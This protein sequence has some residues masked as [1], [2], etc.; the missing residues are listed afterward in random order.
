MRRLGILLLFMTG[1][2]R[3]W[4]DGS[5]VQSG[6]SSAAHPR[7]E[8]GPSS[9]VFPEVQP[10]S[11]RAT[12]A[13]GSPT[14]DRSIGWLY[15]PVFSTD[16]PVQGPARP[17]VPQPGDIFLC[18]DQ[19]ILARWG[20]QLAGARSPHHSG[21]IIGRPD[22]GVAM[23]E[24]GPHDTLWVRVLDLSENLNKYEDEG[25]TIWIRRRKT[26]LTPEQSERLTEFAMKQNGK[27][28][29]WGRVLGQLTPFRSRG[30]WT[31]WVGGPHGGNRVSYF[32][33]ELVLETLVYAGLLDPNRTRPAAT[34]PCDLFYGAST[35]AFVDDHLDVNAYWEPPAPWKRQPRTGSSFQNMAN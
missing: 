21:L 12:S 11:F 3:A 17:Y 16:D 33:S 35:N 2:S 8:I 4:T 24:S 29:A 14:T 5:L 23:L 22:G 19:F 31:E 34:Y 20:H 6:P 28:F 15:Q 26:P 30:P 32:C 10:T 9:D 27:L 18:T 13:V 1:C 25:E 7:A